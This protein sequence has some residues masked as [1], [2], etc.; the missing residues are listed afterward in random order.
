MRAFFK[1]IK[2]KNRNKIFFFY[3]FNKNKQTENFLKI[4]F[5]WSAFFSK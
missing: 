2:V 4:Y 1:Y 3:S 5:N